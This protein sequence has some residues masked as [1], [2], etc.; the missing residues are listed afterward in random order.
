MD[1]TL[2]GERIFHADWDDFPMLFFGAPGNTFLTGLDPMFMYLK[3]SDRS[4]SYGKV[5]QTGN[6][7]VDVILEEFQSR[8]VFLTNDHGNLRN[9]LDRDARASPHL[10]V[11]VLLGVG[12]DS[13]GVGRVTALTVGL[14]ARSRRAVGLQ[15]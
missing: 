8:F 10:P 3:D 14:Q 7:A 13:T 9:A 11:R 15:A 12:A 4:E 2:P 6:R 5:T 1:N